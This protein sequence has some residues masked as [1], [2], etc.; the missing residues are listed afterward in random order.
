MAII[1][2]A[3]EA[4]LAVQN[5][6]SVMFG[7]FGRVGSPNILIEA[8]AKH[9]VAE[10]TMI[11]NDLGSQN[12]GLGVLLLQD[13]IRKAIGSFFTPNPDAARYH[14]EGKLEVEL[15]PQ[16]NFAEAIRAGG[17]GL[18]GF[19]TKVGLDTPLEKGHQIIEVAG[20]RFLLQLPLQADVS[21]IRAKK[22]DTL[23]NLIYSKSGRN[24]N[25]LMAM[26]CKHCIAE[27]DEIVE[28]GQLN[29]EEIVT[30]FLYVDVLVKRGG[31]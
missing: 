25:P 29:P 16:G 10:L 1:K 18:G 2:T 21:L 12:D 27:V 6:M 14:R 11:G 24:F 20:E 13:K 30:P 23:G 28:P 19:L 17:A 9:D 3:E 22:A 8:L 4:I 5:G 31:Q 26:A 7:G 15:I